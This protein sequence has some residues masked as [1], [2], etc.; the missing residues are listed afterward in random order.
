MGIDLGLTHFAVLSNGKKIAA[1]KFLRRAARKLRR[2]QQDLSR[3]QPGS[4][5]R[6]KAVVRS[7]PCAR[8][9]GRH[10]AGLAALALD[11]DHPRQPSGVRRGGPV[12]DRPRSH[13]TGQVRARRRLG[14]VRRDAGVQGRPVR[15]HLRQDRP[16]RAHVADVLGVRPARRPETA[17]RSVM[18]LP[19]RGGPRPGRQRS[20]QRVGPG[21]LGQLKRLWSA[22]KTGTR[23][24]AAPRSRNPPAR[25]AI[26]RSAP[27]VRGGGVALHRTGANRILGVR[28]ADR[29]R[30]RNLRNLERRQPFDRDDW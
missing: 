12:R 23:A 24:G 21:A 9:G 11:P 2:L 7:R 18:D 19:V 27:P 10:A 20:D 26:P 16:V 29:N 17:V 25:R 14:I 3:K 8:S 5:N 30:Q 15:A 6:K 1:P 28:I 13:Q 4:S 22:G